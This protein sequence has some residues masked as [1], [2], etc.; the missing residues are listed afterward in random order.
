M[1]YQ[2][3]PLLKLH[4]E[5]HVIKLFQCWWIALQLYEMENTKV[6]MKKHIHKITLK[7]KASD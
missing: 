3:L 1:T 2:Y 4:A 7:K 5:P 6:I